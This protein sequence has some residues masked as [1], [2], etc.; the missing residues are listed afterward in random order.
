MVCVK[1]NSHAIFATLVEIPRIRENHGFWSD[2]ADLDLAGQNW[3]K[4]IMCVA[5]MDEKCA[6]A[7]LPGLTIL[8]FLRV[9]FS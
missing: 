5:R 9:I 2:P 6:Y 4:N 3:S 8:Y 1:T 7:R